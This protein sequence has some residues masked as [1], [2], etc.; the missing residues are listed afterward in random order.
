M[1]MCTPRFLLC[2]C[3]SADVLWMELVSEYRNAMEVGME[4]LVV[5]L[6]QRKVKFITKTAGSGA[7][8]RKQARIM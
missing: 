7:W 2:A 8:L 5:K 6:L 1:C 3:M 4:N